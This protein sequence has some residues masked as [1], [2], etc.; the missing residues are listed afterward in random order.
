M[1]RCCALDKP[2]SA[3]L[4]GALSL[5]PL[6]ACEFLRS[7]GSPKA[8]HRRDVDMIRR[9]MPLSLFPGNAIWHPDDI[10]QITAV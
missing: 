8:L 9:F 3:R 1:F 5:R 7:T 6:F 2:N 10:E 4:F